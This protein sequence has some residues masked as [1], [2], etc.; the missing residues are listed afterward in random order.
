MTPETA[1]GYAS[2]LFPILNAEAITQG[3][4]E[5]DELGVHGARRPH[6]RDHAQ[7]PDAYFL[8]LLTHQTALPAAPGQRRGTWRS[9]SPDPANMVTNG[10]YMLES[11]TPNDRIVMARKTRIST[12]STTCR[13]SGSN[14]PRSRIARPACAG[15]EAGEVHIC[16]DVPSEQMDYM[17]ETLGDQ[18]RIAPYLGTLLPSGEDHERRAAVRPRVRQ[19]IS[20]VIDREF[21]AEEIWQKRCI[22]A[23]SFVPARHRP[24]TSRGHPAF[25]LCRHGHAGPARIRAHRAARVR[26]ASARHLPRVE[27]RYNTSRTT[28]NTMAALADMLFE[29]RHRGDAE[30]D[31]KA[32]ATSNYLRR[33]WRAF[34]IVRAGWIGDYNDPQKLTCSCFEEQASAST[35]RGWS[36]EGSMTAL[37]WTE[38]RRT[39]DLAARAEILGEAEQ[40]SSTRCRHPILLLFVAVGWCRTSDVRVGKTTCLNGPREPAGCPWANDS[41]RGAPWRAP[42]PRKGCNA[43]LYP[44][45]HGQCHP[46]DLLH[47]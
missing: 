43:A 2:V 13:S 32:A 27:L 33:G 5:P 14:T 23:Y 25:D 45:A 6:A 16:S 21:M 29:H 40:S 17:R 37:C 42:P 44:A 46:D 18:L 38:A 20:M 10:A 7:R 31:G 11:F 39:T 9:C 41:K 28:A 22:P 1:A 36:N 30:R 4:M 19:A 8:E 35:T 3:E 12:I 47:P 15:F 26:P 24:T 34:D